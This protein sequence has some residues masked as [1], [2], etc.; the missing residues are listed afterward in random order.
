MFQKKKKKNEKKEKKK[1][2]V[3]HGRRFKLKFIQVTFIHL[4]IIKSIILFF[5][6]KSLI[7]RHP[8][9]TV[10]YYLREQF[11]AMLHSHIKYIVQLSGQ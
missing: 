5:S 7:L 11:C 1:I 4:S 8:V 6:I 2:S 10:V 9:N 3:I